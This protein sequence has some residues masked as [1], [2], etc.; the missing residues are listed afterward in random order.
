MLNQIWIQWSAKCKMQYDRESW[1]Y[2]I[3]WD[4]LVN[5]Q[6]SNYAAS[7]TQKNRRVNLAETRV[8]Q[9][10]P[11]RYKYQFLT[12]IHQLTSGE[13]SASMRVLVVCACAFLA[14]N[15]SSAR[16][17]KEDET[18][19]ASPGDLAVA[20]SKHHSSHHEEG[21]GHKHHADHHE[22]HGEKGDKGYKSEHHHDKEKH[23]KHG[24]HH[25]AGHHEEKGNCPDMSFQKGFLFHPLHYRWTSQ[26]PPWWGGTP[27]R[28]SCSREETQGRQ[29]WRE[30]RA[31]KGTKDDRVND[32]VVRVWRSIS[33]LWTIDISLVQWTDE[34]IVSLVL[35]GVGTEF[36]WINIIRIGLRKLNTIHTRPECGI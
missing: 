28:T 3:R 32:H 33:T 21:G 2:Y 35:I 6:Q 18:A 16:V 19:V 5:R 26:I 36:I 20:E 9:G 29:I 8:R 15:F 4:L 34:R 24:K 17:L 11:Q 22:S 23:G 1:D 25:H 27:W 10:N 30:E 13:P 7:Q 31:Q 12:E 14:L